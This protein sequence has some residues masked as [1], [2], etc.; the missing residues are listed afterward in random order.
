MQFLLV[1]DQT[2]ALIEASDAVPLRRCIVE[3]R[4]SRL[5]RTRMK[6]F[7]LSSGF[8]MRSIL[9]SSNFVIVEA[10]CASR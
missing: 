3:I 6:S 10:V 9:C 7:V 4:L 2:D 1:S 5:F 8:Q